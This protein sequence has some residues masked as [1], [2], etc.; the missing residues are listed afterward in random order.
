MLKGLFVLLLKFDILF[1]VLSSKRRLHLGLHLHMLHILP[2]LL[3]MESD[4]FI[5]YQ[6]LA[7]YLSLCA[8]SIRLF[9]TYLGA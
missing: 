3:K 8:Y 2:T 1:D 9:S 7:T 5:T 6:Y 4:W